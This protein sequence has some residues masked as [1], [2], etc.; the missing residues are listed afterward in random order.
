MVKT[1]SIST[2]VPP[3]REV[4]IT[5]PEEIPL[6]PVELTVIVSSGEEAAKVTL[7]DL[8]NSEFFGMWRDRS[9]ITDSAEFARSLRDEAWR[10]SER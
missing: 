6:G 10:R 1:I 2:E 8:L 7:G 5:L 9:D 4:R 3:S